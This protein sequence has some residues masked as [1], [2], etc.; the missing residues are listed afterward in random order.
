MNKTE[1]LLI[2]LIEIVID[3]HDYVNLQKHKKRLKW[4]VNLE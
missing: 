3:T 2:L 1:L 4:I